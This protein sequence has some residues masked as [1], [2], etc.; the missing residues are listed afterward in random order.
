MDRVLSAS[1]WT[2]LEGK[3]NFPQ[4]R[5]SLVTF[6]MLEAIADGIPHIQWAPRKF[7]APAEFSR[8]V[9]VAS[10]SRLRFAPPMMTVPGCTVPVFQLSGVVTTARRPKLEGH[11]VRGRGDEDTRRWMFIAGADPF[12]LAIDTGLILDPVVEE[13]G[14]IPTPHDKKRDLRKEILGFDGEG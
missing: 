6:K 7:P 10:G 3:D 2:W 11:L 14:F 1:C 12:R 4:G 8:M 9:M 5:E 13:A